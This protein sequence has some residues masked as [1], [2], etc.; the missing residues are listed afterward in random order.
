MKK[1]L[2]TLTTLSLI[3]I[4]AYGQASNV[5]W[6][7][8][9]AP[10]G[11]Y[12]FGQD[13]SGLTS[14]NLGYFSDD[15]FNSVATLTHN[16]VSPEGFIFGTSALSGI[17][18]IGQT[19]WIELDSTIGSYATFEDWGTFTGAS[20]PTPPT[21]LDISVGVA[22]TDANAISGWTLINAIVSVPGGFQDTGVNIS[23]VPEP[24]TYA[25]LAGFAAFIF[26]AIRRRNS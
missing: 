24:S 4:G 15:T 7:S 3:S 14:L 25:L 2:I 6:G 13:N 9:A 12:W 20:A 18:Y 8:A 19:A 1:L 11:A 26:V 21:T 5:T 17:D 16:G 22:A 10:G 23:A